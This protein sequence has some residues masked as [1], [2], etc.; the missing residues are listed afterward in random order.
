[1]TAVCDSKRMTA[2]EIRGATLAYHQIRDLLKQPLTTDARAHL[3]DFLLSI[4]DQCQA[5]TSASAPARWARKIVGPVLAAAVGAS[6]WMR[7]DVPTVVAALR[8]FGLHGDTP[9][10]N[11]AAWSLMR[12]HLSD[13]VL[14]EQTVTQVAFSTGLLLKLPASPTPAQ[15]LEELTRTRSGGFPSQVSRWLADYF[16]DHAEEDNPFSDVYRTTLAEL[17]ASGVSG[18]VITH[19]GHERL[20][21]EDWEC[22]IHSR[23]PQS[24]LELRAGYAA[25]RR[26]IAE[27]WEKWNLS[28]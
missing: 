12:T 10:S 5:I 15:V 20:T 2:A 11:E 24:R 8:I 6:T 14:S 7:D 26:F 21:S 27:Y 16:R 9:L 18:E 3:A 17:S 22:L 25:A 23:L 19:V 13:T 1:M 28:R 4:E